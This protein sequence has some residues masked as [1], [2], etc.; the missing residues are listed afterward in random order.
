M[1]NALSGSNT[2]ARYAPDLQANCEGSE[3]L[4]LEV[5]DYLLEIRPYLHHDTNA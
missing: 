1:H 4:A 2:H 5:L 3:I